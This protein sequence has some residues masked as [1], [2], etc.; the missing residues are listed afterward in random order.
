MRPPPSCGLAFT[1]LTLTGWTMLPELAPAQ[2]RWARA[3][4]PAIRCRAHRSRDGQPCGNYAMHGCL[5]CHAH[6]GRAPQVR[7]VA[8]FTLAE[9]A[10]DYL[11]AKACRRLRIG[12]G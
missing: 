9:A 6:G 11:A 3:Q 5:V 12:F 2:A 10:T 7:R 4:R 8:L 1:G